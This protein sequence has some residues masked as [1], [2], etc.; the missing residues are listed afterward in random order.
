VGKIGVQK[1]SPSLKLI[2]I[3]L[4][5][6]YYLIVQIFFSILH[7]LGGGAMVCAEGGM[8]LTVAQ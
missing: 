3:G 6:A 2:V 5:R 1:P 7:D 8:V 4:C